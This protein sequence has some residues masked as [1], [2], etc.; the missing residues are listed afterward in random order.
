[1]L[2]TDPRFSRRGAAY[3]LLRWGISEADRTQLPIYLESS[4]MARSLYGKCGFRVLECFA[5][6]LGKFGGAGIETVTIMVRWPR[7]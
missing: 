6:D 3:T 7:S 2:M 1:M 4:N 5:M